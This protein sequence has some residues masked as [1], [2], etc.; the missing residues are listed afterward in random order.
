[1]PRSATVVAATVGA[2]FALGLDQQLPAPRPHP[3]A[4]GHGDPAR[5]I[6]GP[7]LEP[8]IPAQ[9][10]GPSARLAALPGGVSGRAIA[11]MHPADGSVHA[12]AAF[13]AER[14]VDAVPAFVPVRP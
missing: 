9:D 3:D 13:H 4:P 12:A 7:A 8:V 11:G 5:D 14:V 6:A 10:D 2:G 1:M